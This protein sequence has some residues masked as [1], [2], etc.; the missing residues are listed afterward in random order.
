MTIKGS[1]L[2]L[3]GIGLIANTKEETIKIVKNVT[4]SVETKKGR[5]RV[6]QLT[7]LYII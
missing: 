1:Q 4:G 3:M 7:P 2:T 6:C 5:Y